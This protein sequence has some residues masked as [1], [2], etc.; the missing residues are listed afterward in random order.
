MS[1]TNSNTS[2]APATPVHPT[3]WLLLAARILSCFSTDPC[4][5]CPCLPILLPHDN[6]LETLCPCPCMARLCLFHQ[7]PWACLDVYF[8]GSFFA[9]DSQLYA[10]NERSLTGQLGLVQS[11]CDF[12]GL[13]LNVDKTQIL[14]FA[15]L[16]VFKDALTLHTCTVLTREPGFR[17]SRRIV[18]RFSTALIP[19]D[20]TQSK[21][22]A[23]NSVSKSSP[24]RNIYEKQILPSIIEK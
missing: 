19:N 7:R 20:W 5:H 13:K 4:S 15:T 24:T 17:N 10:A 18:C 2:S 6:E 21:C 11:F 16:S 12:S 23:T 22:L 1:I 8:I 3:E 9:D 14:T